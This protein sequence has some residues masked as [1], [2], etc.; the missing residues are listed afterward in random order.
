MTAG[1][2]TRSGLFT[3]QQTSGS[4]SQALTL[5]ANSTG[6][7]SY[8]YK[9]VGAGF[10]QR[11]TTSSSGV[12]GTFDAFVYGVPTASVPRTG[13]GYYRSEVLGA[14]T[15]SGEPTPLSFRGTGIVTAELA[16]GGISGSANIQLFNAD[17]S[18]KSNGDR[19]GVLSLTGQVGASDS[20][21]SGS[22]ALAAFGT[23]QGTL[24][25]GLFGPEAAEIGL[26]YSGVN[27]N[28][29]VMAGALVGRKDSSLNVPTL[30]ELSQTTSFLGGYDRGFYL[31]VMRYDPVAK[32]YSIPDSVTFDAGE[33]VLG[34][35]QRS[36]QQP[37]A[38][39]V[40]YVLSQAGYDITGK[41]YKVGS[42]NSEIALSYATFTELVFVRPATGV[43]ERR[44]LLWGIRTDSA[45]MPKAGQASYSG[46][47]RGFGSD[48][49]KASYALSG[50]SQ[51]SVNFANYQISGSMN[52]TLRNLANGQSTNLGTLGIAATVDGTSFVGGV[53]GGDIRGLF[54]GPQ[55][56]ELGA[57]FNIRQYDGLRQYQLTVDG[58][59]L[60]KK[61]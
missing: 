40:T 61:N 52:P 20:R 45:V 38:N 53:G 44:N 25:G 14:L 35:Q 47:L 55:A 29:F 7:A 17:G 60:A 59:L 31:T 5:T 12:A 32:T 56:E 41:V 49:D 13:K 16:T 48:S 11:Q 2:A 39:F 24:A 26:S 27:E 28:G 36:A 42:E 58:V 21:I 37:D 23:Y 8:D 1:S 34:P 9:Y 18:R 46:I 4:T 54:F 3:Y 57:I 10:W 22:V 15:S 19:D 43:T 30:A 50:T 51:L 6:T 33:V